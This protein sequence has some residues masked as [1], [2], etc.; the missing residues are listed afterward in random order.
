MKL[1]RLCTLVLTLALILCAVTNSAQQR[2]TDNERRIN[3]LL[4]RMTLAE[5]LGQLQQLDGEGNGNFRPEHRDLARKGLLGSTLNVRGAQR[6]NELQ[7]VAM[8]E[9]RLKIPLIFGFDVIHGY[10][11]IF[12]VPLGEASSWDP[13]SAERSAA[14]AAAEARSAGVHWTFAPMLDIARDARWGRIVEGAGEDPYL[15]IAMARARVRGF[16]GRD[17]SSTDKVLACAKHWVAYGA[18]EAGRDYNTTDMSERTLREIYFPPFKAA[19]DE[20]VGTFMSAF[21]SLNGVPASANPFTL[22]KVLR[23]E[24]KFDGFVVSDYTSVEELIK[25][26]LAANESE[27]ARL[28]LSAGVDMEMV[29]RLYGKHGAELLR[30]GQLSPAEIDEAVRRILRIKMRLGLFEHPYA[31]EARERSVIF[32]RENRAAAREIASRSMVLLKNQGETLPLSKNVKSIAL[33]GPLADDQ[34]DMIGSWTGDGNAAAAVTLLAGIKARVS[35]STKI[36]YAKGCDIN[37]D[38]TDGFDAAVRA[39]RNS[40]VVVVAVGESADMSGEAASRSS[41]DL[42]GRQLDL[43]KAVQATG[44][45]TIV[46]LMNGRPLTI[47]W[48]A[49]NTPAILETWF[50]GTQA[51]N[52]IAD[53]LFGDVNPGGKLPV[54]FPRSVGQEPLYYNHMNTGR[55]P[56]VNNKYTSKYLDVSWT[57]LFPFGYGLSYTQ[58]RLANLRLSAQRI[59]PDGRLNVSVD[60]ENTGRFSG[61]EVV[62]LYLRDTAASAPRPVKELKGFQRVTLKPG[63]K[64]TIEFTLAPEQLGFYNREMR[65]VVEPGEFKVMLGTSSADQRELAANFEVVAR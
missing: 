42:P 45:P 3:A 57:P 59:R 8:E 22:T 49:D 60:I 27:A 65:F 20:G 9:S 2:P 56:D 16:Q 28:A 50:A 19:V 11:T 39:A 40:D 44:K 58:F 6:T 7:R 13:A 47:N 10:R 23:G 12:P 29:S 48:I 46:V 35:P 53:V 34:V 1:S 38:S 36:N 14:I 33:I 17:Y 32:S 26:G 30:S 41:L 5:K 21:N 62:Q 63:E 31:D 4:A 24:W 61:D 25:H 64:R 55:P 51:G 52:A 37:G 54:T 15:G 18:A 43:V